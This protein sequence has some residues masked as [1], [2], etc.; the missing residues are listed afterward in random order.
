MTALPA[1]AFPVSPVA[2]FDDD[3]WEDLLNYIEEKRVI[4][5]VGPELCVVQTDAG[6]EN[7]YT[8]LARALADFDLYLTT[9]FDSLLEDALNA[10]RFGGVRSTDVAAYTPSKLVDL[11]ATREKLQRPL[12]YHLMGRLS[13]S[14]TYVIS[15]ED[16]LE[17]VCA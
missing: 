16:V 5:I 13:A 9:T 2:V 1:A 6:P 10:A 15:D 7:L 4:P 17:C 14:P 3:A 11:P 12:V 8:W